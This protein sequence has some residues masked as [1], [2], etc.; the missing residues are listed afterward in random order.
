MDS[1]STTETLFLASLLFLF[2]VQMVFYWA[3]FVRLAFYKEKK[4]EEKEVAFPP[5]SVVIAARNEYYRL[6]ENLPV[7]L[8]QDYPEFEVV[9]V[10]HASDDETKALLKE[11]SGKYKCLKPI[12]IEEDLNFFKGK[13]FPLSIGIKSAHHEILLLTDADCRPISNQWIR[14]MASSYQGKTEVVLGYGPYQREKGFVNLLIRYDA[15]LV[16]MNYLSFA[17]SGIPYMGVGRNLSYKK[18]LFIKNRGFISNYN[19][20]S[21]DDDLFIGQVARK[22]NTVIQIHPES[23]VYSEP[24]RGLRAWLIQK[25]RHLTTG[26][27]YNPGIKILL[28]LFSMSQWFYYLLFI[29]MLLFGIE[30]FGVL[31]IVGLRLLTRII[32]HNKI[33]RQ[34]HDRQ[35]FVFSLLLEPVYM[36]L[37]PFF[38]IQGLFGKNRQWK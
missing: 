27:K 33:S 1:F 9:V 25:K 34:L 10:N 24:K 28:A 12:N 17:L 37:L 23:F 32:I 18:K 7:I 29:V 2:L 4:R 20:A 21:G 30:I 16:A 22:R 38:A 35:I 3:I 36:L 13:K 15:L 14:R 11:L 8:E 19:I 5:V 26:K 6:K 31:I